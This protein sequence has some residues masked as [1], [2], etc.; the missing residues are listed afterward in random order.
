MA[1][2]RTTGA[3]RLSKYTS[4][5]LGVL[6]NSM[7]SGTK[8]SFTTSGKTASYAIKNTPAN[9]KTIEEYQKLAASG[10]TEAKAKAL[11]LET[12]DG[13]QV[14]FGNLEKKHVKPDAFNRGDV[15]EGILAAAITARF[16]NKNKDITKQ[17][18]IN[19]LKALRPSGGTKVN[20]TFASENENAA[21]KDEVRIVISLA[22]LNMKALLNPA[23]YGGLSDLITASVKYANGPYITSWSKMLYENNV[24][25]EIDVV[26]DGLLDQSGTKVDLRV[27]VDGK[28]TN[29]NVSLK[30]GDVKQFGQVSGSKLENMAALFN[31]LGLRV[32]TQEAKFNQFLMKKD[33]VGATSHIYEYVSKTLAAEASNN[34]NSF[35][36]HLSAFIKFHA[37]RNEENVTLVQLNRNE[38]KIYDFDNLQK[39]MS[40]VQPTVYIKNGY[41]DVAKAQVPTI[42][43]ADKSRTGKNEL[44][45]IRM[46]IDT[47]PDGFYHRN[48]IEKG[49]LLGDLIA[50]YA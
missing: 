28:Q 10:S 32:E 47:R 11:T 25:N 43:I 1:V 5:L 21:I 3:G 6:T 9:K 50:E 29:V 27:K 14:P 15:S 41:S 40:D 38:A 4:S 22:E 26:S 7:S 12:T 46:K 49:A 33:T 30:A 24:R 2:L 39:T 17:D 36:K 16:V 44:L 13:V 18:A 20:Q 34:K 23:N 37:T 35:L 19:I 8:L 45:T 42:V 48:Y 31:P